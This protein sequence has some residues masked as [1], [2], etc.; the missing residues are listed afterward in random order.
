M[1]VKEETYL[2]FWEQKGGTG[3]LGTFFNSLIKSKSTYIREGE[4]EGERGREDITARVRK[5]EREREAKSDR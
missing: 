3:R 1:N 4:G 2:Y 5:G